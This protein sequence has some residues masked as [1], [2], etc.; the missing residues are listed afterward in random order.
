[1]ETAADIAAVVRFARERGIRLAIK[2]TGHD[3]L[4]RS[5]APGSLLVWTH[6]MRDIN[7]HAAFVPAE[8]PPDGQH[9]TPAVT[10]AAGTRWLEVYQALAPHG[11]YAQGGPRDHSGCWKLCQ[12]DR[13][14]PGPSRGRQRGYDPGV[15]EPSSAVTVAFVEVSHVPR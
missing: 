2:G 6:A 7:V 9:G 1:V 11:R 5:N 14:I 3:Y 4:G 15:A 13:H 10:V 8:A 12:R